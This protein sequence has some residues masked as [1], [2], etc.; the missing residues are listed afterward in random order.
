MLSGIRDVGQE[1][2]LHVITDNALGN[3]AAGRMLPEKYPRIYWT[4]CAAHC[5]DLMLKNFAR[6]N[7]LD[8][9]LRLVDAI[10]FIYGG[11]M[12]A[13]IELAQFLRN[14]LELCIPVI[15]AIDYYMEGKLDSELH[16]IAYYLNPYYFYRKRNEIIS[17]EKIFANVHRFIQRF[18]PDEQIQGCERNWSAFEWTQTKKRNK[19]TVQRQND[20]VFVQFNS[21]TKKV[22]SAKIED[23]PMEECEENGSCN[24]EG[25]LEDESAGSQN[26]ARV[27]SWGYTAKM[28]DASA[29]RSHRKATKISSKHGRRL[30]GEKSNCASTSRTSISANKLMKITMN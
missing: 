4:S 26:V 24:T 10:G 5:I 20:I 3:L 19:L 30:L 23:P 13:R 1:N 9:L 8:R 17:S 29:K 28:P 7:P 2:V 11:L 21:R 15:N 25:W 12:D 14:E 16:L 18:Y 22:G 27:Q 6:I